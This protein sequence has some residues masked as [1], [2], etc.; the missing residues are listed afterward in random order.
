KLSKTH[1][2]DRL[3][4]TSTKKE[5]TDRNRGQNSPPQIAK[6]GKESP[7]L[8]RCLLARSL[9]HIFRFASYLKNLAASDGGVQKWCQF[10]WG[11]LGVVLLAAAHPA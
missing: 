8:Q 4:E 5:L 3:N 9:Q 7:D 6:F 1:I 10:L 11:D 2:N